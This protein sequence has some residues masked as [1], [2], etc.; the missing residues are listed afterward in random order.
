MC[1]ISFEDVLF[2]L[3]FGNIMCEALIST[4]SLLLSLLFKPQ[5]QLVYCVYLTASI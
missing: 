1:L 3:N 5:F 4:Y 2:V